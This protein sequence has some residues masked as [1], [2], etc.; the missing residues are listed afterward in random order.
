MSQVARSFA[1][2][3]VERFSVQG[4]SFLLSIII[5]RIVSPSSYGLIV[6]VQIFLSFSQLFIDS[7]FSNALIQ[8]K[9]RDETDYCTVFFFNLGVAVILY[10]LLFFFAPLIA[11]FYDEPKL[12]SVTRVISLNLILSSLSIVQRTRLTINLDFKT[13]TRASL[14]AVLISGIIGII[15]AYNGFEVW[16]LVVQGLINQFCISAALMFFSRWKPKAI[17]SIQSFKKL[18][19]F[20]S[21]LMIA[22]ILTSIYVNIT[23]LIIGKK[24][25]SADLALYNRG[26]TLS[27]FA[28]INI[29]DV[30]N[31]VIYPVLV[32]VQE[33]LGALRKEYLKYLHLS[34]Y[35]IL[36]L[37]GLLLVLSKPL[38]GVLLTDKWIGAVPYLQIFCL[39]FMFYPLQLQSG[40]PVA[41]LGHSGIL[42]KAQIIKRI[43]S[44]IILIITLTISIP[45]VCWG[46]LASSIFETIVNII[47]CRKE[48][49]VGFRVH[50]K[51][52][53]DVILSVIIICVIVFFVVL[54]I[55]NDLLKV[56][57]GGIIGVILY[58]I[59][60]WIFNIR[61]KTY[62]IQILTNT[63]SKI[64]K[65]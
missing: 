8:K 16:A 25:S 13:Q 1:W 46:I 33:D 5:A 36:P 9:D 52:L 51:T 27:Q 34:Y 58:L 61:E 65:K 40:N 10:L 12:I 53:L 57:V 30:M 63:K 22:N 24:Y 19:T 43:V 54:L 56:F 6:M 3:A 31:R 41:A 11:K 7:G 23:N 38:I 18:F 44:F 45:A 14:I 32:K 37:M 4:I 50:I 28:S 35:I 64:L 39:N 17:F 55:P 20:G 26:F 15:C 48:I 29:S 59:I 42:L 21:K 60:T 49:G 2:S 47:V 62:I